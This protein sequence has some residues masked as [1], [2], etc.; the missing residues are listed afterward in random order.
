MEDPP[1][2]VEPQFQHGDTVRRHNRPDELGNI[3]GAGRMVASQ[4]YYKVRFDRS[5]IPVDVGESDLE[6]FVYAKTIPDLL[7][8]GAFAEKVTFSRLITYERLQSPLND[9]LYSLRASRTRFMSPLCRV[10][11]SREAESRNLTTYPN[12]SE[13]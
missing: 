11:A 7:R 3:Q 2:D 10:A 6:L 5:V 1:I 12:E 9:N 8:E 4:F 13:Q